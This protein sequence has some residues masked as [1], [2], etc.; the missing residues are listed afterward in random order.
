MMTDGTSSWCGYDCGEPRRV[1][2]AD[3]RRR[4]LREERAEKA[5]EVRAQK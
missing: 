3:D 2:K 1:L 5:K 4:V